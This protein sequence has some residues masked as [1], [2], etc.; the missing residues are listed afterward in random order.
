MVVPS[1]FFGS[2]AA[3]R[4][5]VFAGGPDSAIA[6]WIREFGVG[7]VLTADNVAEV[8]A[9]LRDAGRTSRSGWRNCS[10]VATPCTTSIF[11]G[12]P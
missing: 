8:A 11:P 1:K 2:L 7:W 6:G 4:P 5:V 3:G 9:E 10:P 12:G